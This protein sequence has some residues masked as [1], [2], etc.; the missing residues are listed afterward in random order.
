[1]ENSE[2][3]AE[4]RVLATRCHTSSCCPTVMLSETGTEIVIVGNSAHALLSSPAVS[5]K[6]G[7]HEAAIVIP[8]DLLLEAAEAVNR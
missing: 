6:V 4:M 8:R 3:K 1:M 2:M 5:E 7:V